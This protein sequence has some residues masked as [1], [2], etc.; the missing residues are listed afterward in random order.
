MAI[1]GGHIWRV[2]FQGD[3]NGTSGFSADFSGYELADLHG[4][5][6]NDN[7]R[8]FGRPVAAQTA[9]G[10]LAVVVGSGHRSHPL[11]LTV[12]DRFYVI[13]DPNGNGVPATAPSPIDDS[14]LQDITGFGTGFT[15]LSKDGWRFDLDIAGEKVFNAASV[16]RGE[17]FI[18]TYYPPAIPCS[19]SPDGS[20]LFVLDLEGK[21]TRDLDSSITGLD[22]FISTLN[23]GIVSEYTLHYSAHD[24]NVRG[25]N[26]PNVQGI[27][28]TGSLFD[29][30]WTNNP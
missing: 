5:S 27:Y 11:D 10:K 14:D 16:L 24:G 22:P 4:S 7:R 2:D 23:F 1:P 3:L 20:R 30:F 17:L 13:Y 12:Q 15:N 8:F 19:N 25:I 18:S 6:T 29:R 9:S 26:L 28:S 21:P